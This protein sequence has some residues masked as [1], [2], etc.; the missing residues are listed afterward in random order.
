MPC[1]GYPLQPDEIKAIREVQ[2][3]SQPV[4]ARYQRI[5]E[6]RLRLGTGQEEARRPAPRRENLVRDKID[7]PSSG[8]VADAHVQAVR[9]QRRWCTFS[10]MRSEE[11]TSELQSLMRISYAVFCLKKKQ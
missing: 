10:C 9:S 8:R 4:F 2:D 3:V 1:S 6:P 11:H 5:E 7:L